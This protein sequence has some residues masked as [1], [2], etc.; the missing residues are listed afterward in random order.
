MRD[1]LAW[2][3]A[4]LNERDKREQAA[5]QKALEAELASLPPTWDAAS[6]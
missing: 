5:Q 3:S 2:V 4:N 6:D 1:Y